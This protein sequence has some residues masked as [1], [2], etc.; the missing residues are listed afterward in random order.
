VA[1]VLSATMVATLAVTA[2]AA[3]GDKGV[4]FSSRRLDPVDFAPIVY[5]HRQDHL[6]PASAGESLRQADLW[7]EHR[8]CRDDHLSSFTG[9]PADIERLGT[10]GFAHRAGRRGPLCRL[11]GRKFRS[12]E[13]TRPLNRQSVVPRKQGFY[14]A[15]PSTDAFHFGAPNRSA[16]PNRTYEGAPI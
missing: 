5:L 1:R 15:F 6:R 16:T 10:G 12:N 9:S 2:L 14:V 4:G 8:W 13:L 3:G 7:W 11:S